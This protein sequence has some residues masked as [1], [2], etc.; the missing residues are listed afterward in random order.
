MAQ[1]ARSAGHPPPLSRAPLISP[2]TTAARPRATRRCCAELRGTPL[3][4]RPWRALC[5][6]RWLLRYYCRCCRHAM[7]P[8][9]LA[10]CRQPRCLR[11]ILLPLPPGK[12][13]SH[14]PPP[15]RPPACPHCLASACCGRLLPAA[16]H[17]AR[18]HRAR[19]RPSPDFA[20]RFATAA[21]WPRLQRPT[22]S[23][24]AAN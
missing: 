19:K 5:L 11:S 7:C 17:P 13:Q 15:Q 24:A 16:A 23:C 9:R 10:V 21:P 6:E 12:A 3:A 20:T 4:K 2:A 1:E 14:L 22:A 18:P 8:W